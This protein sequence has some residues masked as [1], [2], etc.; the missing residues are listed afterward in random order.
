M[1]DS[2]TVAET[3]GIGARKA[4][5]EDLPS[6]SQTL[7]AAFF[8]DPVFSWWIGDVEARQQILPEFF[9]VVCEANL[10]HDET[11][12]EHR[13]AGGAVWVP[14]GADDDGEQLMDALGRVSGR[15]A[16]TLFGSFE[17]MEEQHPREPHYYLF[18]LGTRPE[19]Q[20]RGIGSAL[21]R[22]VLETCDREG[23]PAYLEATSEDNKRLYL[24]HGF[25]V[26]GEIA[27]PPDGPSI[28]PMWR[29]PR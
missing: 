14:P 6:L 29:P 28:W 15:Y 11:Y 5:E 26:T 13:R 12:I 27:L 18:F 20:R 19:W 9:K 3:R 2:T 7:A 10:A 22:P 24:R 25:H 4:S 1:H 8:E 17:L 21:M 23:V 16:E